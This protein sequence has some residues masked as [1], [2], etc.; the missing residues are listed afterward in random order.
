MFWPH[1]VCPRSRFVVSPS[2]L[3]RLQASLQ[4]V[5]PGLRALPRPKVQVFGYSTKTE[6]R[7][8]LR[9]VP[10][11]PEQ[12][13]QPGALSPGA[14]CLLP[15]VAPASVSG[16]AGLV[17]LASVLGSWTLAATVWVDVGHPESQEVFG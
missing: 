12:L 10:S 8:G 16:R 17:H 9:F 7:L 2:T 5:G 1:Q 11:L 3:L 15:S 6:T 13:S 14:T 4:G